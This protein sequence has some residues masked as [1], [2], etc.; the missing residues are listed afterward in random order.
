VK[1]FSWIITA[2]LAAYACQL[3]V[4]HATPIDRALPL[5]AV[6]VT[7]C[8]ALSYPAVM[9]GVPLLVAA[10]VGVFDEQVRL[11]AYG[12]I[13]A[14]A[15]GVTFS[16]GGT[17]RSS[18][19]G[20]WRYRTPY[21]LA[22]AI[23]LLRWIP[24]S[25]VLVFR[26]LVLLAICVA[27]VFALGRTPFGVAIAVITALITPAIPLRTLIIPLLV[28]GVAVAARM[29]GMRRLE[30]KWPSAV[31]VAFAML[32][33][34][35][36]G[37]V[38]RAF[39]YLLKKQKALPFHVIAMSIAPT[40]S[41]TLDVPEHATSLVVSGANVAHF[42]RGTLLGR[43]EP[44]GIDV[45]IGDAADWGALRREQVYGA[46]NPLP[47][48]PAG[49]IRGYGY[50]AWLDGAGRVALPKGARTIHVTT[51]ASLPANASLQI[52]GFE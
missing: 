4:H 49:K 41:L 33:F 18:E 11:L 2:A 3:A 14:A 47:R 28:L 22:V 37:V 24:L 17:H 39:P 42:R 27:I 23:V 34:A 45:R 36:S 38:A 50:N 8:A 46:H 15:I 32:F 9:V 13:V 51:A 40:Q 29:F 48:D 5:L 43:I 35:W 31:V 1:Q 20:N 12:V 25:E 7:V 30:L 26:E 10:S 6:A 16:A 21:I 19:S 52:E 44:G